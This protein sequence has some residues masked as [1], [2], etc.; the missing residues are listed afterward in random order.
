M[1]DQNRKNYLKKISAK[2]VV[3][4]VGTNFICNNDDNKKNNLDSIN[5]KDKLSKNT[6]NNNA[7]NKK[8]LE[9]LC[10]EIVKLRKKKI[11]VML[12]T[13][14]AVFNGRHRITN[15]NVPKKNIKNTLEFKQAYSAIGQSLLM[16]AYQ[17]EF[18]KF[19]IPIAQMLLT[20]NDFININSYTNIN[21]TIDALLSLSTIPI[22]NENDTVATEELQFGENDILS[23]A[24][25]SI[26]K[27]DFLF[28]ITSV[29]G[30]IF[31]K[32]RLSILDKI[33]KQHFANA[34][35]PSN[36]GSGGMETKLRAAYLSQICGIN[37]VILPGFDKAPIA[38]F[39][40]GNDIGTFFPVTKKSNLNARQ[41]WL[42]FAPIRSTIIF[43]NNSKNLDIK[44]VIS[45][46]G[47]FFYNEI[48]SIENEEGV[49][50][51][52]GIINCDKKEFENLKN[53]KTENNTN[54][55]NKENLLI[56][57][58]NLKMIK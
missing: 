2:R 29:E 43:K 54:L 38:N 40:N 14:G 26:F 57:N 15:L 50:V 1:F 48:V 31:Q 10:N 25:A 4:K 3:I 17:K 52:R 11:E 51:G 32:K 53:I 41:K 42:V 16:E 24:C 20:A 56:F 39:L 9:K 6:N 28:I 7:I 18:Q 55:F 58:E 12:V 45:V 36:G 30:F 19:N 27:A 21:H 37:S 8:N 23:A 44:N 47:S 33:E 22:V 34:H 46:K 5:Q 35:G 49:V 13:S